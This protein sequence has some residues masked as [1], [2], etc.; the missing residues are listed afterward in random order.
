MKI[1]ADSQKL[2]NYCKSTLSLDSINS[3]RTYGYPNLPLCVIDAV[4]SIGVNYA[5]TRNVVSRFCEFF[6]ISIYSEIIPPPINEQLSISKLI[7][8]FD[9]Y[10]Y[11]E[12]AN[13]VFNNRNRTSTINGILKSEAVFL[14]SKTLNL[15]SVEYLQDMEKI[16]N[17]SSF[18]L[19]I[20]KIPGQKSGISTRYFYMLSGE[21][22][23]IKPD[24]MILR[25]IQSAVGKIPSINEATDLVLKACE[26]LLKDQPHLT[27]RS[28]DNL[29]WNYQREQ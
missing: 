29:I 25:Y 24:R 1:Q 14:F 21:E 13:F 7:G 28:L 16:I 17:S 19:E 11:E 10:G 18:E 12:M 20:K 2:A 5:S 22:N 15:F 27:P 8:F 26:I 6:D 4:F 23:F 9:K 3:D